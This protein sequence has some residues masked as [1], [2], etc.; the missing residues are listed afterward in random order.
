VQQ[1]RTT[2]CLCAIVVGLVASVSGRGTAYGLACCAE[3]AAPFAGLELQGATLSVQGFGNVGRPA[4]RFLAERGVKLVAASD[5]R[6]A[7]HDPEGI[8]VEA[9][10]AVKRKEGSVVAY[11]RGWKLP[12]PELLT[13]PCDILV[14]AA[15]PDALHAGNAG[16]VRARLVV[17]G[18]NIPATPE[19]EEALHRRG[20][21]LVPDF[22][23]NAGGVICAATELHGGTE[24]AAFERIAQKV[25]EN[26]QL[27]LQRARAAG[28]P[29]RQA[30]LGLAGERVRQAMALRRRP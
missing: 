1:N 5:S 10:C 14:P 29:P 4:A 18:A 2:A 20:V 13:V 16:A 11:K 22:I 3:V 27:V 9:L 6:G 15:R 7:V 30:A 21:L 25:R 19:A 23:A 26:T 28:V 24:A 17:S 8:D 12:A